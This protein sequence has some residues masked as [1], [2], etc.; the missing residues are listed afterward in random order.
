MAVTQIVKRSGEVVAFDISKIVNAI[1][2]AAAAVGG[3]DRPLSERLAAQ[4]A[5]R[6]AARS[7]TPDVE[8]VQDA[9]ER[10]L[11]DNGHARTAKAYIVYRAQR[12]ALRQAR[13]APHGAGDDV[14]YRAMWRALVFNLEHDCLT[15]GGLN[16]VIE[17]GKL[18]QLIAAAEAA[19][20]ADVRE[21]VRRILAAPESVRFVFISGPSSSGKTT[22]TA[23]IAALLR[24]ADREVVILNVDN[25]FFDL[26]LHPRD[27]HGD[28]DF[29][30]PE[31]LDLRLLNEH[32]AA[33][34]RAEG[35]D[36][37]IYDF[38][39]G[40]RVDR[41]V[42]MQVPRGALVLLDTL[43][44]FYDGLS[45]RVANESK[46]HVYLETILQLRDA[47]GEWVRWTDV[48]LLRRMLRDSVHRNYDPERTLLHW[49][50]VRR[51]EMKHIIPHI[52]RAG[53]VVNGALPYELPILKRHL[54]HHFP[55][56]IAAWQG[57]P[58]RADALRR[59]ER[60]QALLASLVEAPEDDV[61]PTSVLRE[62]I[63]GSAYAV[64]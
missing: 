40:C 55:R 61:P 13:S 9:V 39:L 10:V 42:R 32:L 25:Y 15:V 21:A 49:H 58:A 52:G 8:D 20:E 38:K 2:K 54:E 4:V 37:P 3:H 57:D 47:S 53:A 5:A 51:G 29:E 34:D 50:Y 12:A 62:F 63:G 27:Q 48:R 11:I 17:T 44:G 30:T 35:F 43:H 64:H 45:D 41:T 46:F 7:G 56:F 36:M 24:A 26:N 60:I 16:R 59:A 18:P 22:T 33:I 19:Y 31:A 6:L 14:P 1:Y 23:K 28:Y